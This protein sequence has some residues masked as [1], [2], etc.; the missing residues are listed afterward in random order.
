MY[1]WPTTLALV[2]KSAPAGVTSTLMGIAFLSPFVGHILMGW[3]GSS[4]D[5]MTPSM[6]WTIDAAIAFAGA[7]IILALRNTLRRG[8]EP[9]NVE[10]DV[11]NANH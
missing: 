10:P 2:S 5:T 9:A 11:I 7:V 3:V 6:F 8:L 1:Y 4:F